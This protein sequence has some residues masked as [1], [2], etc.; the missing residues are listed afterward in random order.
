MSKN[1]K[2]EQRKKEERYHK[3][4]FI[5]FL[6]CILV[7]LITFI[8]SL[9]DYNKDK[10]D[11]NNFCKIGKETISKPEVDFYYN[12]AASNYTETYQNYLETLGLDRNKSFSEQ[13]YDDKLTWE[14][15]FYKTAI[16]YIQQTRGLL[17]EMKKNN[18]EIDVQPQ[19]D[20]WKST[21]QASATDEQVT[22]EFLI[23]YIYGE[24][25][26][27][28]E[29]SGYL[30]DYLTSTEYYQTIMKQNE[31]NL[32][33][34]EIDKYINSNKNEFQRMKYRDFSFSYA[35]TNIDNDGHIIE[36]GYNEKSEKE[37]VEKKANEFLNKIS[38]EESFNNICMEYASKEEKDYYKQNKDF[39][40]VNSTKATTNESFINWLTDKNRKEGDKTVI[41]DENTKTYHVLYYISTQLDE[42]KTRNIRQIYIPSNTTNDNEDSPE[43]VAKQEAENIFE[44]W[45]SGEKTEDSFAELASK[46]SENSTDSDNLYKYIKQGDM[47]VNINNW[48]FGER[49]I[50]DCEVIEGE[51][52]YHILYF[53]GDADL[54]T[55]QAIAR[56]TIIQNKNT[57]F[58]EKMTKS[59]PVTDKKGNLKYLEK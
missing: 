17:A 6:F 10:I 53:I 31:D 25:T 26:T 4:V 24:G 21:L 36:K 23:E 45:K 28:E 15:F 58:L 42:S 16:E 44:E 46:Y 49:Q 55:T 22:L 30:R 41:C 29:I 33:I 11:A 40:L 2:I 48:I 9:I 52:G 47:E 32:T 50:G 7:F 20:E 14:D 12:L 51:S 43:E 1:K 19:I 27:E 18:I 38:D 39:S 35:N 13:K 54:N 34:E 59:Y 8:W 5:I 57:E 3:R 56:E 37:K